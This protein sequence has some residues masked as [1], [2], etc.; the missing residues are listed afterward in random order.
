MPTTGSEVLIAQRMQPRIAETGDDI[1]RRIGL[2]GGQFKHW[3]DRQIGLQ[4]AFDGRRPLFQCQATDRDAETPQGI[5]RGVDACRH[6]TG[7]VWIDDDQR[8]H[9]R[10]TL[11]PGSRI[12]FRSGSLQDH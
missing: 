8:T 9:A 3:R 11:R 5:D 4:L 7:R 6:F 2:F 10:L 12:G 1:A